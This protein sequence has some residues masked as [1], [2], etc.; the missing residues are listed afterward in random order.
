MRR[1]ASPLATAGGLLLD[2]TF[3]E[4]P[5]E[6]HPVVAFGTVMGALERRIWKDTRVRGAGY[7]SVGVAI[8]ASSGR[9]LRSTSIAVAIAVAGSE[10]RSVAARIA[11]Y[12]DAADLSAAR[13]ALPNLVG[14]DP[15]QLD[16][17]GV[18]AAVIESLAENS[19]DAVFAPA[20]WGAIAGPSGALAYRAI[21][22]MD[23][24]VGHHSV[25]YERFGW[26]SARLDDVANLVPARVFAATIAAL[27]PARAR[28]IHRTIRRD[29]RL[30]PSPNA[31]VAEAAV[32]A[33]LDVELGG[34][35]HYGDRLEMRPRLGAG[36][37]PQ[38][39]DIQ[40]AIHL[41]DRAERLLLAALALVGML[42][43]VRRSRPERP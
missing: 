36:R 39:D 25:R 19:V 37:R 33:A 43:H 32:A 31:G 24:M 30:H 13:T 28:H 7:A 41:V 38:A 35:L 3:G 2:R 40:R 1:V 20:L 22:T 4:P 26:A 15:S 18:A 34:P 42:T 6:L 17:S 16:S 9:M 29:A 10:L 21:N 23:S 27:E 12:L 5:R 14:R 11:E 8:G